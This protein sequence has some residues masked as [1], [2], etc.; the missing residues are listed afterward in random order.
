MTISNADDLLMSIHAGQEPPAREVSQ[1]AESDSS[2]AEIRTSSAKNDDQSAKSSSDEP[3]RN[4]QDSASDESVNAEM[5]DYGNPKA[6]KKLYTQEEVD[7]RI[8]RAVRERLE[9]GR[10][11]VQQQQQPQAQPQQGDED[12]RNELKS[13]VV[14]TVQGMTAEQ[15]QQA[16]QQREQQAQVEFESKFHQGMS[17]FNDFVDVVGDAPITDAMTVATRGMKDPAAFLY[18]AAK[19]Q[20]AELARIA[21][22]QDPYVQVAEM[23]KLEERIR[24]S[25]TTTNAAKPVS[26]F[27]GDASSKDTSRGSIE[28]RIAQHAKRKFKR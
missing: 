22:I 16:A 21:K 8:N 14:N 13:F 6:E 2:T 26:K 1:N 5:D 23:G 7:E 10:H 25:K 15:Q 24:K 4:L 17:R 18:A 11:E 27:S 28:D 20:K 19:T 3:N 12:W 9:R